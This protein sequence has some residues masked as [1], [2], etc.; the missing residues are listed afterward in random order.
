MTKKFYFTKDIYY[1]GSF[2]AQNEDDAYEKVL[3]IDFE[4]ISFNELKE[5]DVKISDRGGGDT[6]YVEEEEEDG[7]DVELPIEKG[8]V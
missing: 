6:V 4:K 8:G 1:M 5:L 7:E 2:T 3:D